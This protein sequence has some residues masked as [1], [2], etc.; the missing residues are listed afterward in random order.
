MLMVFL[1]FFLSFF[2][3]SFS[4]HFFE[5]IQ[6][7][8]YIHY[9]LEWT[10]EQEA[11]YQKFLE[12]RK[13]HLQKTT[14]NSVKIKAYTREYGRLKLDDALELLKKNPETAMEG[15]SAARVYAYKMIHKNPN[16]YYYRFNAPGE[17]QRNGAFSQV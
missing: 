12:K 3:F 15:W 4:F 9:H 2:F 6:K 14:S 16:R 7:L 1:S 17:K 8:N 5:I 11:N 13:N 10:D